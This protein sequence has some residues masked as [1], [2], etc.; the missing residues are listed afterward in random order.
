MPTNRK[1]KQSGLMDHLHWQDLYAKMPAILRRDIAF[2]TCLGHLGRR[3]TVRIVSI[4]QG[5]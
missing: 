5:K 2:L 4:G 3:D 1:S